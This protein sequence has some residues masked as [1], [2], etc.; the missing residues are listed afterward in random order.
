MS[1]EYNTDNETITLES[2][3]DTD[4]ADDADNALPASELAAKENKITKMKTFG[5]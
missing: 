4:D 5:V 2:E 3:A 1:V